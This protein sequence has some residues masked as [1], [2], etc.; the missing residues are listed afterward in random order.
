MDFDRQVNSHIIVLT[1]V[2]FYN[3]NQNEG[4]AILNLINLILVDK[5]NSVLINKFVSWLHIFV[6]STFNQRFLP[7]L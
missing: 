1:K 2:K 3:Q 6:Y 7:A 4:A 5:V